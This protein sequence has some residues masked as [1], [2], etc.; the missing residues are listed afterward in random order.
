MVFTSGAANAYSD[1]VP[2]VVVRELIQN[3]LDAWRELDAASAGECARISFHLDKL[4]VDDIPGIED[5]RLALDNAESFMREQH[6]DSPPAQ[7]EGIV[8]RMRRALDAEYVDVLTVTDNGAG[9]TRKAMWG[10]LSDGQSVKS[11]ASGGAIGNG[12]FTAFSGIRAS[13]H[14][15]CG[16]P[17]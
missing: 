12:H 14:P 13:L 11:G 10:L 4:T 9:L 6:P 2:D 8:A 7:A 17:C 3:S 15:V 16:T 1:T 5:Y